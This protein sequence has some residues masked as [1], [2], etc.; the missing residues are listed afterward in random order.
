MSEKA[1]AAAP[2]FVAK[3]GK[4]A[5]SDLRVKIAMIFVGLWLL[6]EICE[7]T[8]WLEWDRWRPGA[9]LC[10]TADPA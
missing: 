9:D 4:W 2:S 3:V 1:P 8:I 6:N 10:L 5:K 7:C